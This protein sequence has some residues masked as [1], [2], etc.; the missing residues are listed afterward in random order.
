MKYLFAVIFSFL[1]QSASAEFVGRVTVVDGDTLN[2]GDMRVRIYG[3]NAP[4]LDET[5]QHYWEEWDCGQWAR[6]LVRVRFEGEIAGC[7]PIE[8][9]HYGRVV[10]TCTVA[11]RDMGREIVLAG[12]ARA[13]RHFTTTYALDE[14]AAVIGKVGIWGRADASLPSVMESRVS[15][16]ADHDPACRIKGNISENGRIFHLP[17]DQSYHVTQIDPAVGEKW[18]CTIGD[19]Q[20]AGWQRAKR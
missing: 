12:A 2:I 5:C 9:D 10:A 14:K 6:D 13:Y 11:G 3:I 7:V 17:G 8:T 16:S 19:A 4:E 20:S 18:F 1:A 15:Q